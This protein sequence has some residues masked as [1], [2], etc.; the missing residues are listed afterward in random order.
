MNHL[1]LSRKHVDLVSLYIKYL[2]VLDETRCLSML[3]KC[4]KDEAMIK[5]AVSCSLSKKKQMLHSCSCI[6]YCKYAGVCF[7][8]WCEMTP[9]AQS[10]SRQRVF[11][12]SNC[13]QPSFLST[14][15]KKKK[16]SIEQYNVGSIKM[17]LVA[18]TAGNDNI[19][20]SVCHPQTHFHEA[21]RGCT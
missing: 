7:A 13:L 20:V 14:G 21:G 8:C 1:S 9:G 2:S 12:P 3:K 19:C 6:I 18:F 17:L 4:L 10:V 15:L 16:K 11:R 5:R